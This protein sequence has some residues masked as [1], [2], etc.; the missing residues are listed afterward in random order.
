M[1]HSHVPYGEVNR[2]N[3]CE[4]KE[5]QQGGRELFVRHGPNKQNFPRLLQRQCLAIWFNQ[6]EAAQID[7]DAG[8]QKILGRERAF[9]TGG[10]AAEK[11]N[12]PVA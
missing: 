2:T 7:P 1:F 10:A 4:S 5:V 12:H 3:Q 11:L 9:L 8:L 6:A